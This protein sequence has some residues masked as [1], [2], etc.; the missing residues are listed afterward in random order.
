MNSDTGRI[1]DAHFKDWSD[2]DLLAPDDLGRN[3]P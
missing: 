3:R 1:G 2:R